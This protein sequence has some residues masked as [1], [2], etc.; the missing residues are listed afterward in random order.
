MRTKKSLFYLLFFTGVILLLFLIMQPLTILQFKD[1]IAF[2][3]PNGPIAL[4]QRNLLFIIQA[5]MLLVIIPVYILTFVFSWKYRSS[6]TEA[7]YDPDLVDSYVAEVIWWGFPLVITMII[8]VITWTKTHQLDPFRP[9]EPAD[10]KK[11]IQV[12]ALQWR[13]LFIYPE[14]KIATLNFVQFPQQTPIKFE[15]TADAPMNSFWIPDL[16][17]QIYAMPKMKTELNLLAD[18]AGDFRGSSAN[19]SGEGFARMI[20]LTRVTDNENFQKWV[21]SAKQSEKTLDWDEYE[22]LAKP[23]LD[24]PSEVYQLKDD[25]LFEKIV[26]KYM[27]PQKKS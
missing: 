11:T 4:Q 2:L 26:N 16:A 6:N 9:L 24:S 19:I 20:F 3:F 15:I 23:N 14:E 12:V 1:Y 10:K 8:A 18:E 17:G 22:K 13:W 5:L 25:K 21:E 27:H 7:K